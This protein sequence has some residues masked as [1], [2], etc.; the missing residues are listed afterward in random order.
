[1]LLRTIPELYISFL[2]EIQQNHRVTVTVLA[3]RLYTENITIIK[4]HDH[5]SNA[6]ALHGSAPFSVA[7]AEGNK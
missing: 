6:T 3:L 5:S 4:Q 7:S 2:L 1:M